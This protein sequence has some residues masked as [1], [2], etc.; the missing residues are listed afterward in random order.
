MRVIKSFRVRRLLK[1]VDPI[2]CSLWIWFSMITHQGIL[3]RQVLFVVEVESGS[4]SEHEKA[5]E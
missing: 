5:R 1:A 4:E 3:G 2:L